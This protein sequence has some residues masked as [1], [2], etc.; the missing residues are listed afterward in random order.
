MSKSTFEYYHKQILISNQYQMKSLHLTNPFIIDSIC[1]SL[2]NFIQLEI[3]YLNN[4]NKRQLKNIFQDLISLPKLSSL[5]ISCIESMKTANHYFLN[6]FRIPNLKYCKMKLITSTH[7]EILPF[8][9]KNSSPI[10]HFI[11]EDN[12]YLENLIPFL[13]YLPQLHRLSIDRLSGKFVNQINNRN[14][15]LSNNLTHLSIKKIMISMNCFELLI[16][17]YF[18]R[19]QVLNISRAC[20]GEY[21]NGFRWEKLI[22]TSIQHLRIFALQI[23][24]KTNDPLMR[25]NIIQQFQSPFWQEK[26]WFFVC[27]SYSIMFDSYINLYSINPYRKKYFLLGN[28]NT[29]EIDSMTSVIHLDIQCENAL[30]NCRT[31]FPNVTKLTFACGDNEEKNKVSLLPT[32]N[33]ILPVK[34]LMTLHFVRFYQSLTLIYKLLTIASNVHTLTLRVGG[35]S[36]KD[37]MLNQ[38]SEKFQIVSKINHVRNIFIYNRCQLEHIEFL[39]H[40]CPRIEDLSFSMNSNIRSWLTFLLSQENENTRHLHSIRVTDTSK[41]DFNRIKTIVQYNNLLKNNM[42]KYICHCKTTFIWW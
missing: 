11:I 28:E 9:S 31:Y 25:E 24:F 19:L 23:S 4:I 22:S 2:S 8:C 6:I 20:A 41:Y 26:Q 3:L 27:S 36:D 1:K 30:M 42:I 29:T 15:I 16:Q 18:T 21:I 10:E 33:H 37:A 39:I 13:S 40:L 5:T 14:S 35:I 38:Q 17:N 7:D 32:L 12:I 34:Q